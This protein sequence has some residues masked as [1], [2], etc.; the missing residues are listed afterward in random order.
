MRAKFSELT[1]DAGQQKSCCA[2]KGCGQVEPWLTAE[3]IPVKG[4]YTAQDLEGMEHL[5]YA[6]GIAPFL[7]GPYSTMYVMRPW[8]IRQYAG[9]S[10]A[11]ESNAFY[12]RNLPPGRRVCRWH[13]TLLRTAA[14]TPTTRAWWATWA[15]PACR[16]ARSR[17]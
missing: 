5:N 11:E 4:A 3:G 14:T 16:S 9:F 13:S 7:R 17:T 6:A 12:R 1:Y 10:T 15:K 2:S 8:T